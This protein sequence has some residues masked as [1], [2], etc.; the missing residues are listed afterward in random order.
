LFNIYLDEI[1]NKWQ[2]Q[3]ITGIKLLKNQQL[4]TLLFADDQVITADREDNL[5][6]DAHKLNQIIIEYGLTIFVQKTKSMAFRGRDPVKTKIVIYNKIME[7]VNTFN[8][9]GSIS[10]K[11]N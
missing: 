4:S 3:D 1:I 9:L 8:Y 10:Y 6:R 11:N 5:Q 7:K 2:K